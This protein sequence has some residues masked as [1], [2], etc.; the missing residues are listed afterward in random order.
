MH[1]NFLFKYSID[2]L[3]REKIATIFLNFD[4]KSNFDHKIP[5]LREKESS[6]RLMANFVK[7]ANRKIG[8]STN[9]KSTMSSATPDTISLD[10]STSAESKEHSKR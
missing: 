6:S 1:L 10:S 3:E 5:A 9:R 8:R 2:M 4:M 7:A